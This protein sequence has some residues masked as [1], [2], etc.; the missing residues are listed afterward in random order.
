[1]QQATRLAK[2]KQLTPS[3]DAFL[4][5]GQI[6][7]W[8]AAGNVV[9]ARRCAE[10]RGL[11]TTDEL[12]YLREGEH[13]ALARLLMA[14]SRWEQSEAFLQRLHQVA[15][16]GERL[17]PMIE[18]LVLLAVVQKAQGNGETAVTTLAQ[19]LNLAESEGYVR[20]FVDAGSTIQTLLKQASA[21]SISPEYTARLLAAFQAVSRR[22]A[23]TLQTSGATFVEPLS[24]HELKVLRLV[25]AGLTNRETAVEL[26]LSVNTVKWHLKNIYDKLDVHNR[27]EAIARAQELGYL[28]SGPSPHTTHLGGD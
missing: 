16:A 1:M 10:D 4:A 6:R 21:R 27:V 8:L 25:A 26:Y 15:E 2:G 14:E 5:A 24:E 3:T 13:V 12:S 23:S 20:T 9:S 17:R 19:A 18:I 22:V 28:S 11:E 7:A